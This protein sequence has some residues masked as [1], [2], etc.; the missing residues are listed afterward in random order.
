MNFIVVYNGFLKKYLER[1]IEPGDGVEETRIAEAEDRLGFRLPIALR[2]YYHLLGEV[3]ELNTIQNYF[4]SVE[5]LDIEEDHLIF[6]E[7][8][9]SVVSWGIPLRDISVE[10][11]VVWQRNN[12]APVEWYSEEKPFSALMESMFD[13]YKSENIWG[14]T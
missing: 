2:E 10:D 14:S 3:K 4:H 7:E 12:T 8:N 9:Q 13:W 1:E 5:E 11:P 6:M